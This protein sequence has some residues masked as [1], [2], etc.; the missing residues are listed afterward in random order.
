[1]TSPLPSWPDE[2]R[3]RESTRNH[4]R[5]SA[6]DTLRLCCHHLPAS[7]F[8]PWVWLWDTGTASKL[9]TVLLVILV[10]IYF[11][12]KRHSE[13]SSPSSASQAGSSGGDIAFVVLHLARVLWTD[14]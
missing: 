11:Q 4:E 13:Q 8:P 1:M 14:H 12:R 7:T 2:T 6:R 10:Y 9:F 3:V 5:Q